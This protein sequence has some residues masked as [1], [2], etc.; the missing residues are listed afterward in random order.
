M[1]DLELIEHIWLELKSYTDRVFK[2]DFVTDD[3]ILTEELGYYI[4]SKLPSLPVTLGSGC[5]GAVIAHPYDAGLVIKVG[6]Q[7]AED[8]W[9]SYAAYSMRHWNKHLPKIKHLK[10]D[11]TG[12]VAIMERLSEDPP[13][14]GYPDD[15]GADTVL[16]SV[17]RYC[18][19]A[20]DVCLANVM[21]RGPV[22][23]FNDIISHQLDVHPHMRANNIPRINNYVCVDQMPILHHVH[24]YEEPSYDPDADCSLLKAL[25]EPE[26]FD[27]LAFA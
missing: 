9:I 25:H 7:A 17:Q 12:L 14:D 4:G 20:Y 11:D 22:K 23:V 2:D 21:W 15:Y 1:T 10:F 26:P 16:T 13:S 18:G 8:G 27:R 6:L 19:K 5:F 24:S 3:E